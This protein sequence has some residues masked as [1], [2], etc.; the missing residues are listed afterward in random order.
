A[1]HGPPEGDE[2]PLRTRVL[3]RAQGAPDAAAVESLRVVA[4]ERRRVQ[5]G[6]VILAAEPVAIEQPD[7]AFLAGADEEL[8]PAIV[9]GDGRRVDVE[10]APPQPVGVRRAEVVGQLQLLVVVELHGDDRVAQTPV[11]R[12]ELAVA[13]AEVDGAVGRYR[14]AAPSPQAAA[15]R[16]E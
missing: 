13:G 15:C 2:D 6:A 1:A 4:D 11:G 8:P 3:P 14:R 5:R 12:I 7:A 16:N 10:I 9:E